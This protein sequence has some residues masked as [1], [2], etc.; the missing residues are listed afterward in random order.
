MYQKGHNKTSVKTKI[1][2]E[3][4]GAA[5]QFDIVQLDKKIDRRAIN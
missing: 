1:Q 4:A 2:I 3:C 5:N